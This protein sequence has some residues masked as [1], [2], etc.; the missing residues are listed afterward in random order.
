[1]LED[2]AHPGGANRDNM[3]NVEAGDIFNGIF[4]MHIFGGKRAKFA[5]LRREKIREKARLLF[6]D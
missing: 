4:E 3:V 5:I 1:M 6:L 2:A